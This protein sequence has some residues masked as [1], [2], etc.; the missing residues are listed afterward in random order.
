MGSH[1]S[2]PVKVRSERTTRGILALLLVIGVLAAITI[3]G[4]GIAGAGTLTGFYAPRI[5]YGGVDVNNDGLVNET[6]DSVGFM[7]DT[8]LVDGHLDC[9]G[10]DA[11]ND[12]PVYAS[13]FR[14]ALGVQDLQSRWRAEVTVRYGF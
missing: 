4:S 11:T 8:D 10:W 1:F 9:D 2:A 7:G 12:R 6:D 14:E 5:A 3:T 13:S